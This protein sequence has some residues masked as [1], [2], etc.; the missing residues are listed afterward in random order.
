MEMRSALYFV[1]VRHIV[2]A[3]PDSVRA[4]LRWE[5]ERNIICV[6]CF[7]LQQ[8][9]FWHHFRKQSKTVETKQPN[10]VN[11]TQ[12]KIDC[13]SRQI[14]FDSHKRAQLLCSWENEIGGRM[15]MGCEEKTLAFRRYVNA[16]PINELWNH[17]IWQ[18]MHGLDQKAIAPK[19]CA[20]KQYSNFMLEEILLNQN[21]S[22]HIKTKF[23]EYIRIS[24][25]RNF[26]RRTKLFCTS[27]LLLVHGFELIIVSLKELFSLSRLAHFWDGLPHCR[28]QRIQ[29]AHEKREFQFW[30]ANFT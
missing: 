24:I 3:M 2:M 14:L 30:M 29:I 21:F 11:W 8:P 26:R 4:P 7:V 15:K 28:K 6:F 19:T 13:P 16:W 12:M 18:I 22:N 5:N 27:S 9:I 25:T 1:H 23:M 20:S 17:Q 10:E